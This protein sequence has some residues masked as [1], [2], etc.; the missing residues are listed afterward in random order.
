M[1]LPLIHEFHSVLGDKISQEDYNH[2]QNVW[3][4]FGYKNL[5]EYNDFYLKIDVLSLADVWTTF[6]KTSMHHYGLNLSHYISMPSL[7]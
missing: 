1:K 3:N 5:G 2:A 4:E 7:S 6:R